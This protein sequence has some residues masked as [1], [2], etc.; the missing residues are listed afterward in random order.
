MFWEEHDLMIRL[1]QRGRAVRIPSAVYR[2]H[3]HERSMTAQHDTR[4]RPRSDDH[5][6][7]R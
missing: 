2:Y 3:K 7:A 5:R 4:L 6:N 1:R